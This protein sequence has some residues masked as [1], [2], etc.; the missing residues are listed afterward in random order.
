MLG[1]RYKHFLAL[2]GLV[3]PELG[4]PI[5]PG[6]AEVVGGALAQLRSTPGLCASGP[7][8]QVLE[9][10]VG[11]VLVGRRAGRMTKGFLDASDRHQRPR[12]P[13]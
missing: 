12:S 10:P 5:F 9:A 8:G 13:L 2:S 3:L 11:L 4:N 1:R 6:S 7:N